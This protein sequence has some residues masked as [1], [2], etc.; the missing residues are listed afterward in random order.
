MHHLDRPIDR[1]HYL[2]FCKHLGIALGLMPLAVLAQV[3]N[4]PSAT[5]VRLEGMKL[6]SDGIFLDFPPLAD[7]GNA[8]PLHVEIRAP[9]GLTLVALE[10][11]LPENPNPSVVKLRLLEPLRQY[12]LTT[13]LRLAAS[14]DAWVLAT[15]SDG[16][17][18]ANHAPTVI[19]SSAC[20]DGT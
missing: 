8:V 20:F 2:N 6:S 9:A 15:Y 11:L 1:R 3:N 18:R 17:Q 13:R 14:Q 7:T 10:V 4:G 5:A 19:T 12:N 16:S